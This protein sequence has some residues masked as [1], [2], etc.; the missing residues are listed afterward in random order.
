MNE[1][2]EILFTRVWWS[3]DVHDD[4]WFSHIYHW[5]NLIEGTT[6]LVLAGLVLQRYSKHRRSLL[7]IGYCAAFL[8]FAA[9][10]FREAW[11]QSSWLIWLKLVNLLTL[12]CI[13]RK[14]MRQWYPGASVF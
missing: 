13:R 7:E 3:W 6:W 2:L 8:T 12:L 10:D 14:V 1:T 11:E 5:F 4:R 9:S